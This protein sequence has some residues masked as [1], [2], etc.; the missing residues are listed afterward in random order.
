MMN[1]SENWDLQIDSIVYKSL[2]KIPRYDV[3]RILGIIKFL[4]INPYFGD[5]QKIKGEEN[6]WR[7]RIGAYRLFYKIKITER[8]ILIFK[9]ERR[10]SN[11]Y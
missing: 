5:I 3:E 1:S 9:L 8:A 2:K 4:P 6:S 11:V 7:R 10:S